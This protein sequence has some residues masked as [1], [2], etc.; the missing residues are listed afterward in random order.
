MAEPIK[1]RTDAELTRAYKKL[2]ELIKAGY[3]PRVNWF[4]NEAP[5]SLK[6][7][8]EEGLCTT[9]PNF[10]MHLWCRLVVQ[11]EISLNLLQQCRRQS[12][13]SAYTAVWGEFDY[14][15]TPLAPP[16]SRIAIHEKLGQHNSWGPHG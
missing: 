8:D 7:H 3:K 2:Q 1:N 15:R 5:P 11:A 10:L 4:D 13:L 16:G 12:K 6:Q 14:N 9:D